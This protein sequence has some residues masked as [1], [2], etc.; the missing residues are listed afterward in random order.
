MRQNT[1][2][3]R[4]AGGFGLMLVL[5]VGMAAVGL[6]AT[7]RV[8]DRTQTLYHDRAEPLQQL[9]ELNQRL[10]QNQALVM[11]MLINPG[12]QVQQ[13]TQTFSHNLQ[14]IDALWVQLNRSGLGADE[15]AVLQQ[16]ADARTNYLDQ[17]LTP[18]NQA[19]AE[20]RFDDAQELYLSRIG[21]QAPAMQAA[22]DRWLA[23]KLQQAQLEFEATKQINQ[24][25]FWVLPLV[26]TAA[27][28]LGAVLAWRITRSITQPL[29]K[30]V[31]VAQQVAQGDLMT[32]VQVQG[33][34]ETAQLL[35]E[36]RDMQRRLV[37]V[38]G[39][40]RDSSLVMTDRSTT[41]TQGSAE[42]AGYTQTQANHL[43]TTTQTLSSLS[44]QVAH[45][46]NTAMQA[47]QLAQQ[48]RSAAGTSS[49]VM[50][51]VIQTMQTIA[52][53]SHR[54]AD[55]T[56]LIDSIAFQTNIL[57]LN[58][59]V[60]AARA[61][62]QGRGFA[63]VAT[64]VRNLAQRS[65]H[66]A[67]DIRALI[68]ES[69]QR[70]EAGSRLVGRAGTSVQ[71]ITHQID[72]LSGLTEELRQAS[73][74]QNSG[75]ALVREAIHGLDRITRLNVA[76]VAQSAQDA[77]A[78]QQQAEVLAASVGFFKLEASPARLE[79]LSVTGLDVLAAP[80]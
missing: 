65:A 70:V 3:K 26:A 33:Q 27:L 51:E 4:L 41:I 79:A 21:P 18:A 53:S 62:D 47:S 38:V 6:V 16:W 67:K 56:T 75:L 39:Q 57:A 76:T 7:Q 69:V 25:V 1:I 32:A 14:R 19:M 77:Q 55:I 31:A 59:A 58:A 15:Q 64:E 80:A 5:V 11:D 17:A 40:V 49:E 63:V 24:T 73:S 60:E 9:A 48:A 29:G 78:L 71:D 68:G 2:G 44:D 28:V 42:V 35:V 34:G 8:S 37:G 23:L 13:H 72:S 52:Q 74:E 66:A 45:N 36:L 43:D 50:H 54:I 10:Q 46:A 22:M 12:T 61:G 20:G 30:A